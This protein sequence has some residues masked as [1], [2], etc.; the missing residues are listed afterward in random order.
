MSS[1]SYFRASFLLPVVLP[2]VVERLAWVFSGFRTPADDTTMA[3]VVEV[4]YLPLLLG[5]I[6]YVIFLLAVLL[7]SRRRDAAKIF[8]FT[9][10][11][12]WAFIAVLGGYD[13]LSEVVVAKA[14]L[15][16]KM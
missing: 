4:L 3:K 15:D 8:R 12:P 2:L 5:G 9:F 16:L 14:G 10:F 11:A 13:I 1:K 6:P 7:W